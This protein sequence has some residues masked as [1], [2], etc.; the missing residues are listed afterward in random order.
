MPKGIASLVRGV[1]IPPVRVAFGYGDSVKLFFKATL[2][3]RLANHY[4]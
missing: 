3:Q 4:L 1:L 2:A